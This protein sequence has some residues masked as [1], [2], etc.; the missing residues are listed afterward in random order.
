MFCSNKSKLSHRQK[1]LARKILLS[2]NFNKTI[3][4]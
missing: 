4:N 1:L 2:R 3:R